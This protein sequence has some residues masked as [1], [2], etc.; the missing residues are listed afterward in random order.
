MSEPLV[1][2]ELVR[3]VDPAELEPHVWYH[4]IGLGTGLVT[5]GV[6]RYVPYQRPVLAE[7]TTAGVAGRRVLD[8]GCRDGIFAFAAEQQG[9]A[10]VVGLDNNQ[11]TGAVE[12]LAPATGSSVRFVEA[13]LLDV[14]PADLGGPFD[15]VVAA[16]LIYHLREPFRGLRVLRDLLVDGGTLVL[17]GG[18]WLG[19]DRFADLWCPSANHGPYDATSPSFFNRRAL[20]E[21]LAGLGLRVGSWQE[22]GEVVHHPPGWRARALRYR[23]AVDRVTVVARRE[24]AAV[25]PFL[26]SYFHGTHAQRRWR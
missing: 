7:M 22:L 19:S 24:D 17:E 5:P 15:V 4:R 13:N 25:D 2:L 6:E 18:I 14:T 26:E 23:R 11:S 3:E 21:T 8:A 12:V 1:T 9:A 16:G 10:E 20:R